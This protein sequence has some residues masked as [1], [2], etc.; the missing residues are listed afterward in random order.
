MSERIFNINIYSQRL[1]I[2][3]FEFKSINSIRSDWDVVFSLAS[4]AVLI[5]SR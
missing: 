5:L 1:F 2:F 4:R 3:E